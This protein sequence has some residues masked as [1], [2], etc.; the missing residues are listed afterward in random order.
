MEGDSTI[1]TTITKG[2]ENGEQT[3]VWYDCDQTEAISEAI[4]VAASQ[5]M[6]CDVTALPPLSAYCDVDALNSLFGTG[7]PAAPTLSSGILEFKYDDLV[8]TIST[9]GTI[10]IRDA[11]DAH[12]SSD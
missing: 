9:I 10:E 2:Q 3:R 6:G 7:Q 12:P 1:S 5:H 8:V 11:G 4:L